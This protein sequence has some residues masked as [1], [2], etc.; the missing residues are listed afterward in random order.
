MEE[1]DL[2]NYT[3]EDI[4]ELLQRDPLLKELALKASPDNVVPL[5]QKEGLIRAINYL[6]EKTEGVTAEKAGDFCTGT[7]IYMIDV[8]WDIYKQFSAGTLKTA[9][10][11]VNYL[12]NDTEFFLRHNPVNNRLIKLGFRWKDPVRCKILGWEIEE[13]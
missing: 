12:S 11:I 13:T 5:G 9:A 7:D 4:K 1:V 3:P 10:A 8:P 6:L 2:E